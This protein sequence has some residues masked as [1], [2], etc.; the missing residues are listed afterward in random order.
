MPGAIVNARAKIGHHVILYTGSVVEHDCVVED[1]VHMSPNATLAGGVRIESGAGIGAG[2]V[3][4][5][6]VRIG[7]NA[8]VGAGAVVLH[9]VP[10][11]TTV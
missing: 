1:Y 10:N 4:I 5:H 3:V 2:A 8:F 7:Q 11:D 6:G 9:D